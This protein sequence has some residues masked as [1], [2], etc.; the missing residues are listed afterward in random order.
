MYKATEYFLTFLPL[1]SLRVGRICK[2]IVA[3]RFI[4]RIY[5]DIVTLSEYFS[6]HINT[7]ALNTFTC[8]GM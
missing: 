6:W 5:R 1:R 8:N 2:C 4:S 3:F 7:G